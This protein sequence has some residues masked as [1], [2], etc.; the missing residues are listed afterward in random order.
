[1]ALDH[2]LI[3]AI[4]NSSKDAILSVDF[5]G[6]IQSWNSGAEAIFGHSVEN[7]IGKNSAELLVP[8]WLRTEHYAKTGLIKHD[9]AT[10]LKETYRLHK[11]GKLVPV[12]VSTSPL[13][14]ASGEIIGIAAIYRDL[15]EFAKSRKQFREQIVFTDTLLQSSL[16]CVKLLDG[17]GIIQFINQN[18]CD[19]LELDDQ[20]LVRG[21]DWLSFWPEKAKS[22]V[23][24][25][26]DAAQ[27]GKTSRFEAASLTFK[28]NHRWWDVNVTPIKNED[29]TVVQIIA[30][31]RD[32]TGKKLV[33]SQLQDTSRRLWQASN[34]AGLTYVVIDLNEHEISEASNF[35]A[36]TGTNIVRTTDR[37]EIAQ[38]L[39]PHV[40]TQDRDRFTRATQRIQS[41]ET[42]GR[43]E[44]GLN[45][46]DDTQRIFD[47]RWE[48]EPESG[49]R[50][51]RVFATLFEITEQK[52]KEHQIR[53]LMREVNHRSKNLL[54]VILAVGRHTV[55]TTDPAVFMS[56]FT[57]R[58]NALSASHDLLVKD[59]WR[60]V[61]LKSLVESQLDHFRDLI[62]TRI[63]ISGLPLILNPTA[64]QGIGM[65]LHEL[66]TNAA[67]FGSLSNE[68]GTVSIGW[69]VK[70]TD[71]AKLKMT[72]LER[73]GP[74][75]QT[76]TVSKSGFG[77][78]VTGRM[79]ESVTQGRTDSEIS[80][81]GYRW[82]LEAPIK[83]IVQSSTS[84]SELID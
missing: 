41:G 45:G 34:A 33:E 69:N 59:D 6:N 77:S 2:N 12:E 15:I 50:R 16:D 43:V 29:D 68:T 35:Y 73:G 38:W 21:K 82:N 57:E 47:F 8:E 10:V 51:G 76:Q 55:R 11:S 23:Q 49:D 80:A 53:L 26:V 19:L 1:M 30:S 9:S 63:Q 81:D 83:I 40:V 42:V 24:N 62:G 28:G 58:I 4:F 5:D 66:S 37:A 67:K 52:R 64:A 78:V 17:A 60:G 79:L 14:S 75:F 70:G 39:L 7:A 61:S 72:W 46:E 18:G 31:S 32:V 36:V 3:T 54:S 13:K 74:D 48:A 22:L 25:S 20:Q 44:F 71:H 65:A 56:K 27:L 84:D